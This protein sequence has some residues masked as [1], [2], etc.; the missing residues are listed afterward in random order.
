MG[1][2]GRQG[3]WLATTR[4]RRRGRDY[5]HMHRLLSCLESESAAKAAMT[6]ASSARVMPR[7]GPCSAGEAIA[8]TRLL[9]SCSTI[10]PSVSRRHA[11]LAYA[12]DSWVSRLGRASHI[13]PSCWELQE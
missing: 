2:C 4:W 5:W 7:L 13:F 6:R 9:L 12:L 10:T 11:R 8:G 1:R 3:G